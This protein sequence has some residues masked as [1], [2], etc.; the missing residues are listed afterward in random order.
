MGSYK[1]FLIILFEGAMG[2]YAISVV[3]STDVCVGLCA[4]SQTW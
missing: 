4:K 1:E 2:F 3:P